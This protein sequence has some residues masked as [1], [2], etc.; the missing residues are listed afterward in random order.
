MSDRKFKYTIKRFAKMLTV[1]PDKR[2]TFQ[3]DIDLRNFIG[4]TVGDWTAATFYGSLTDLIADVVGSRE[5]MRLA[6]ID[7]YW[8][9]LVEHGELLT[10]SAEKHDPPN[11]KIVGIGGRFIIGV[12]FELGPDKVAAWLAATGFP[13]ISHAKENPDAASNA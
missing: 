10:T 7:D 1:H 3:D 9:N 2:V 6:E 8:P 12:K 5:R 13:Q 4:N 11:A